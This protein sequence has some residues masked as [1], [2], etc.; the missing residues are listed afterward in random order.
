M[1]MKLYQNWVNQHMG[2]FDMSGKVWTSKFAFNAGPT[3]ILS[4]N[5]QNH[6]ETGQILDHFYEKRF[7]VR[8]KQF[9]SRINPIN[10]FWVVPRG[11]CVSTSWWWIKFSTRLWRQWQIVIMIDCDFYETPQREYF[12]QDSCLRGKR[13]RNVMKHTI[14]LKWTSKQHESKK[15]EAKPCN[16]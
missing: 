6:T 11:L 14:S 8:K 12:R 7:A 13:E 16:L 15:N 9:Y 4:W 3:S 5:R 1:T 10:P 2:L